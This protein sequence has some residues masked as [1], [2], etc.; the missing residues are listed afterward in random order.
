MRETYVSHTAVQTLLLIS[1]VGHET[2]SSSLGV[3]SF[4]EWTVNYK[5]GR[6]VI[7]WGNFQSKCKHQYMIPIYLHYQCFGVNRTTRVQLLRKYFFSERK[8]LNK[9]YY[10]CSCQ[11]YHYHSSL[12]YRSTQI[13]IHCCLYRGRWGRSHGSLVRMLREDLLQQ[14]PGTIQVL[15]NLLFPSIRI[16]G[17]IHICKYLGVNYR[18]NYSHNNG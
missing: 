1:H 14:Y 18:I 15:E 4:T 11:E 2:S 10:L 17:S 8:F 6:K 12:F 5:N 16:L 7:T 13:Q 9:R 3:L